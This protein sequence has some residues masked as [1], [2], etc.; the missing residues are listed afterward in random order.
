VEQFLFPF[1]DDGD[2]RATTLDARRE[3]RRPRSRAAATGWADRWRRAEQHQHVTCG[4]REEASRVEAV[5][6]RPR[7]TATG[8]SWTTSARGG[9]GGGEPRRVGAGKVFFPHRGGMLRSFDPN[10]ARRWAGAE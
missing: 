6:P 2:T 9:R 1:A 10:Q 5:P 3:R 4:G 8:M 7:A